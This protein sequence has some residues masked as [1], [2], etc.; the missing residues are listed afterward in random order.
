MNSLVLFRFPLKV[1]HVPKRLAGV[2]IVGGSISMG[3]S[4]GVGGSGS[5]DSFGSSLD[6]SNVSSNSLLKGSVFFVLFW[7]CYNVCPYHPDRV[8]VPSYVPRIS[9]SPVTMLLPRASIFVSDTCFISPQSAVRSRRRVVDVLFA[10][11]IYM[12]FI[13]V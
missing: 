7:W 4:G 5:F 1:G 13:V 10:C 11:A 9:E 3:E 8:P 2:A 6:F 12:C